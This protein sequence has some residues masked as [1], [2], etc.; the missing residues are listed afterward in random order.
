MFS[1]Q[2]E[3][4]VPRRSCTLGEPACLCAKG[5]PATCTPCCQAA[6][7]GSLRMRQGCLLRP[8]VL[9]CQRAPQRASPPSSPCNPPW[10]PLPATGLSQTA[11]LPLANPPVPECSEGRRMRPDKRRQP[12]GG[13][14]WSNPTGAT[15]FRLEQSRKIGVQIPPNLGTMLPRQARSKLPA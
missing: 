11:E 14:N 1:K 6:C 4:T 2:Q 9:C 3:G 5:G 8:T 15:V 13:G 10:P 12:P 7:L